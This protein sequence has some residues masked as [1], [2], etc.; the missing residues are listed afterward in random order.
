MEKKCR[1]DGIS[2]YLSMTVTVTQLIFAMYVA[3]LLHVL[4]LAVLTQNGQR[5]VMTGLRSLLGGYSGSGPKYLESYVGY[6]PG[7]Q[8]EWEESVPY[9]AR[10]AADMEQYERYTNARKQR[11]K[12]MYEVEAE[13]RRL[14][15]SVSDRD[16]WQRFQQEDFYDQAMSF[17][18]NNYSGRLTPPIAPVMDPSSR[19]IIPTTTTTRDP[20]FVD[21]TGGASFG[22]SLD[23]GFSSMSAGLPGMENGGQ[24]HHHLPHPMPSDT[25]TEIPASSPRPAEFN[26][27]F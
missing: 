6:G 12:P 1:G 10:R 14:G 3:L 19:N 17:Q 7:A 9:Y 25:I 16:D 21:T 22:C 2:I 27:G 23:E 5:D 8:R 15:G 24:E 26:F 20:G 13:D 11:Q 18:P 4:T